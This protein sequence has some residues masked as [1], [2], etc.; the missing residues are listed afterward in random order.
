MNLSQ[1]QS[2]LVVSKCLSFTETARQLCLSQP[3]VS[4][5][6][7]ALEEE[8]GTTL[9]ERGHSSIT[10]TAAGSHLADR[11][12]PLLSQL[13]SLLSQTNLIG[14]GTIGWLRLGLLEDQS[15]DPKLSRALRQ[16]QNSEVRLSVQRMTFRELEGALASGDID[17]AISIEQ[18]PETF[19][20]LSRCLYQEEAMCLAVHRDL[21]PEKDD[22]FYG[23]EL[24]QVME[25]CPILIPSLASFQ[26]SQY[27]ALLSLAGPPLKNSLEYDFSSIAPMVAAGLA[28]TT[29]N[30]SHCLS[31]DAQVE[32][33]PLETFPGVR[34]GI[35]WNPANRNPIIPRLVKYLEKVL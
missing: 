25:R 34:K 16:L 5:Q 21:L 35:F 9:F 3:A 23:N 8:L 33:I 27:D 18:S 31:T 17:A 13:Q 7:S 22:S 29:A 24:V 30:E 15:L 2:F 6:M 10:L 26:K 19:S 14:E 11:L 32:M 28:A 20:G 1:L 4:R 12:P